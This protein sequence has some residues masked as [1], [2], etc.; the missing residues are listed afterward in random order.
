LSLEGSCSAVAANP[1]AWSASAAANVEPAA[2]NRAA[3]PT[4]RRIGTQRRM[5]RV[6]LP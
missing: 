5:N 3:A 4:R 1:V 6:A 2:D